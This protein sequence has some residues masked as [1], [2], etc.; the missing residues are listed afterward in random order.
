MGF[1]LTFYQF[2]S[3]SVDSGKPSVTPELEEYPDGPLIWLHA[4]LMEDH[5]VV[6]EL[7]NRFSEIRPDMSFLLTTNN[8]VVLELPERCSWQVLPADNPGLVD[9][10][11]GYWQPDIIAW[12]SGEL[13]PTLMASATASGIPLYLIDTGEAFAASVGLRWWPGLRR[14]TLKLFDR[15]VVGDAASFTALKSAGAQSDRI[16][17][18]GVLEKDLDVLPCIEDERDALAQL[19]ESRPV[20]LAAGISYA[21]LEGVLAAHRQVMRRA[22]RLL[23]V[24]VPENPDNIVNFVEM[25]KRQEFDFSLRS[26]FEEP[27]S[28]CQVYLADTDD[29]MGLWYRL[30]PVSFIGRTLADWNET[31]PNPFGAAALGSVVLHGPGITP[32]QNAFQRLARAGASEQVAHSSDLALSLE[33]LLAPDKAAEMAN[34]AWEISTAGA[35]VMERVIALLTSALDDSETVE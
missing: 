10:F 14:A 26:D 23:L 2:F 22:H 3:G 17:I 19:L 31:G 1:S 13:R 18:I 27:E 28:H 16:E 34:A 5:A 20:W 29:E 32:H 21:E 6:L 33:A 7:I 4:P 15:I 9:E 35:E 25:F 24:I 12:L 30:A 8:S 11:L